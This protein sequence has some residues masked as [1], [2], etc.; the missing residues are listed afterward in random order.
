MAKT[1]RIKG[2]TIPQL[3]KGIIAWIGFIVLLAGALLSQFGAFFPTQVTQ[4]IVTGIAFLV[5]VGVVLTK[6]ANAI[7][8]A[9]DGVIDGKFTEN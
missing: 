3:R 5:A 6:N 7:D 2:Y 9:S 1:I 8:D 4:W